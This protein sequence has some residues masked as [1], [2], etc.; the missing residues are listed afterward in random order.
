MWVEGHLAVEQRLAHHLGSE[1][2]SL[3]YHLDG[4][5]CRSEFRPAP[6]LRV[7]GRHEIG[8][9]GLEHLRV[10]RRLLRRPDLLPQRAVDGDHAPAEDRAK[11][12]EIFRVVVGVIDEHALGMRGLLRLMGTTPPYLSLSA[13]RTCMGFS[14]LSSGVSLNQMLCSSPS[15]CDGE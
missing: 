15:P 8:E 7:D 11:T 14:W 1:R 3:L 4:L 5:A 6:H 9:I 13:M 10:E 2:P 12:I